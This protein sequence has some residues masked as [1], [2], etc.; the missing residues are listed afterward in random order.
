MRR[1]M[2]GSLLLFLAAAACGRRTADE[3]AASARFRQAWEKRR[4]GDESGYQAIMQDI[5]TRW[6]DSRAGR[7]AQEAKTSAG[8]GQFIGAATVGVISAV[9]VP[10]LMKYRARASGEMPPD[11]AESSR[12]RSEAQ[13]RPLP[14]VGTLPV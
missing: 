6:P 5:A 2:V 8:G 1:W 10:A 11:L 12:G 14:S 7:R 9:A 13:A 3:A 4:S